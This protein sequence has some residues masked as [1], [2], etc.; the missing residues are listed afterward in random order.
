MGYETLRTQ[1]TVGLRDVVE[2]DLEVFLRHEHDPE[3]VRRS[4]FQP[5]EREQLIAHWRT[6]ILGD[7]TVLVRTA[8]VDGVVAG[9][10]VAWWEGDRRFLGYVFGREFWGRGIGTKALRQFLLLEPARPLYADPYAG[11]TGSCRLLEK[12]GF[13]RGESVL[14]GDNA[15]VM[16]VL[17]S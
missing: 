6:R 12:V 10:V 5:R 16:Y 11:N 7:S 3:N 4:K 14:H 15:H 17:E 13:K 1:E 2:A 8:V 9:S